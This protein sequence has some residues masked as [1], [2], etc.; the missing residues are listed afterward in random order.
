M[1][2]GLDCYKHMAIQHPNLIVYQCY[3]TGPAGPATGM[4]HPCCERDVGCQ[5]EQLLDR[6]S[7][8]ISTYKGRVQVAGSYVHGYVQRDDVAT[9]WYCTHGEGTPAVEAASPT[10][11]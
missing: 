11:G 9:T 5:V 10:A 7:S 2:H 6:S 3:T 4:L 1:A 8:N